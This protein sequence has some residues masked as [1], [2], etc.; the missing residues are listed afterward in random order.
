MRD[1]IIRLYLTNETKVNFVIISIG[2]LHTKE[3]TTDGFYFCLVFSVTDKTREFL[4]QR[5]TEHGSFI[6]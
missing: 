1:K 2:F 5:L 4:F 6:A 3:L